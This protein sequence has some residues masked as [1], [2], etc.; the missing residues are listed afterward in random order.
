[1]SSD[2]DPGITKHS[3]S[4]EHL[5]SVQPRIRR[6]M[7]VMRRKTKQ[8]YTSV[9]K[10]LANHQIIKILIVGYEHVFIFLGFGK[11]KIVVFALM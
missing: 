10:F 6:M 7:A 4:V 2:P 9:Q 5:I 1:M 3:K 8:D 11:N